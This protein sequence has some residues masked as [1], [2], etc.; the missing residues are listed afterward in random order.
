MVQVWSEAENGFLFNESAKNIQAIWERLEILCLADI[1]QE[2]K[3]GILLP[4]EKAAGLSEQDCE[5]FH[6]PPRNPYRIYIHAN[7]DLGHDDLRY[8]IE[9][10]RP[11]GQP[12]INPQIKGTLIH[13]G[14]DRTYRLNEDQYQMISIAK[15]SNQL[16]RSLPSKQVQQF[17]LSHLAK[18][19]RHA[20]AT[21]AKLDSVLAPS[22]N[23][24]VVPDRLDVQFKDEPDGTVKV[25]PVLLQEDEYGNSNA[26]DTDNFQDIFNRKKDVRGVYMGNDRTRYVCSESIQEGLKQVKSVPKMSREEGERYRK[27]PK[28]LFDGE[29][30]HFHHEQDNTEKCI[31]DTD[32][33]PEEGVL[34]NDTSYSSRVDGLEEL[35]RGSYYGGS[36]HKTDWLPAEGYPQQGDVLQTENNSEGQDIDVGK[37]SMHEKQGGHVSEHTSGSSSSKT[38]GDV[39]VTESCEKIPPKP[40]KLLSLRIKP[41]LERI[42]YTKNIN[43]RTVNLLEDG[44]RS[45]IHL[46]NYQ[47]DGVKWMLTQW[48]EGYQGV[49]LAD[50]MGLGKTLQT[51]TFLA[52]IKK[53]C[54]DFDKLNQPVLIVAPIALLDNWKNEYQKFVQDGIFSCVVPLHGRALHEYAT[55]ETTLNGKKKL[56]M[57]L[58]RNCIALTTYETLRDYQFSFAEV[59]WS[60]IVVD[61]AQKLK[62]PQT[63]VTVAIKAMKYDYAVCLSGTPVENSWVDLWSIM[64]FV[65]PAY[66]DNLKNFKKKYM[67]RLIKSDGDPEA[68]ESLGK[69]LKE[70][71]APIFLRRMKKDHLDGIPEKKVYSCPEQMPSYQLR[72]Y[73]SVLELASTSAVHPLQVIARL[74]DISLHPDIAT[75]QLDAFY[76]MN[77]DAI[78]QQSA[79]LIKTFDILSEVRS[80]NEKAL[81]FL[82][83]RKMQLV[84]KYILNRKFNV[85]IFPP[86]NGEMNGHARQRIVDQFNASEG[87]GVLILSPEAAGV[88]F[89]ITSANNVIHLSRTWNPA[90]EDQATDRVY[91]IGQK[92]DVN[93]YIPMSCHRDFGIGGSFDEKLDSLLNYKRTLSENVLYPTGDTSKDGMRMY[94]E[95]TKNRHTNT[96]GCYWDINSVDT[97]IGDVFEQIVADLYN[98]MNGYEA[99]KTAHSNDNGADVVVKSTKDNSGYLIQCKHR[100]N[101][102]NNMDKKAIQEI[103]AAVPYYAAEHRGYTFKPVVVTNA[104]QFTAGAISLAEKNHVRLISRD[105][106]ASLLRKYP[107]LKTC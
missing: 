46:L 51:L 41:N 82:V 13:L 100:D 12:F 83:S 101:S 3:N 105:E 89:T 75:K 5:L 87:F 17:N 98:L 93:V 2:T 78:I 60:V 6:F 11:D 26:V 53:S 49:L 8:I 77:A 4:Y 104:R 54:N 72:C 31:S 97:V 38:V 55:G 39:D 69:E 68:I 1:A 19:Q 40:K 9:V 33:L 61:E 16:L 36:G 35:H 22:N 88:G 7:G 15:D 28:E 21:D 50:D 25:L 43:P 81:I 74:R 92:R 91:R 37:T 48:K 76:N 99:F 27:Q 18:I 67:E 32:W 63:G 10:I 23:R 65:Q 95:L 73:M 106:L 14:E 42:D 59:G 24:I 45:G 56:N 20:K 52:K 86:I 44:L 85:N 90:K 71:L 47:I 66:L 79:R 29:V 34:E 94:D 107:I 62:N 80:R 64:D 57:N 30:F 96:E 103:V 70:N 84:L 102:E 58:P